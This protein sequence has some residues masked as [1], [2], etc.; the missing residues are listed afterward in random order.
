MKVIVTSQLHIS[1]AKKATTSRTPAKTLAVLRYIAVHYS[2]S[3]APASELKKL[4]AE[5][6]VT[7]TTIASYLTY[8]YRFHG[9]TWPT[10]RGYYTYHFKNMSL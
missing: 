6:G 5:Y 3:T 1:R 10:Y 7:W 9:R 2:Y 4:C 8:G